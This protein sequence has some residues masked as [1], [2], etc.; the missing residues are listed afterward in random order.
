M[1]D[2]TE[3]V[4]DCSW[5]CLLLSFSIQVLQVNNKLSIA[6]VCRLLSGILHNH[7]LTDVYFDHQASDCIRHHT[8]TDEGLP[9][10]PDDVISGGWRDILEY[11]REVKT[12]Y[13]SVEIL[14]T[15]NSS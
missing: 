14:L 9:V 7:R 10:P 11:L 1:S 4:A 15:K 8:W 2:M 13:M 3:N 6:G 12:Q 5:L